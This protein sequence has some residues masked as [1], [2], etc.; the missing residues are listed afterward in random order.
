[1][2]ERLKLKLDY[3]Y[4][5]QNKYNKLNHKTKY[6]YMWRYN[7]ITEQIDALE[8]LRDDKPNNDWNECYEEDLRE[9][10]IVEERMI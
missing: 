2:E 9:F 8:S 4:I 3:L 1:M 6:A 10:N 5:M 7:A